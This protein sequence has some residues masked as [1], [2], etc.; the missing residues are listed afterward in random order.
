MKRL[1]V[2]LFLFAAGCTSQNRNDSKLT[3]T[4]STKEKLSAVNLEG[5]YLSVFN[6]DTSHLKIIANGN[7]ITGE[8]SYK[9]FEKDSNKGT[10]NG[11]IKDS[12]IVAYYTFQS[13]G[14]TS[15]RE[16]AFKPSGKGLLEG[17][18]D[19]EISKTGDTAKFTHLARLQ[20]NEGP[21]FI[22]QDCK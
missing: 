1:F 8:L 18:G 21:T 19:I 20:F 6:K 14:V 3:E 2:I 7:R 13:E 12:L 11:E 4:K 10:I 17:F 16:V 9:R 5:C 22:K 15:V